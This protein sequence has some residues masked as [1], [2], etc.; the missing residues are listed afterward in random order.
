MDFFKES[1]IRFDEQ[2]L[3]ETSL[4]EDGQAPTIISPD[5]HLASKTAPRLYLFLACGQ[6]VPSATHAEHH[7][8]HEAQSCQSRQSNLGNVYHWF[9]T[10]ALR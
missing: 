1:L 7:S 5:A 6:G 10:N 4:H 8:D 3:L 9:H 2:H